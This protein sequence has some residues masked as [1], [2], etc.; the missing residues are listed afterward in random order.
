LAAIEGAGAADRG[1]SGGPRRHEL[2]AAGQVGVFEKDPV[3]YVLQEPAGARDGTP[4]PLAIVYSYQAKFG[5]TPDAILAQW[6]DFAGYVAVVQVDPTNQ[7]DCSVAIAEAAIAGYNVDRNAILVT[8]WQSGHEVG[9]AVARRPDLFRF[10]FSD[11]TWGGTPW[12]GV[13][14]VSEEDRARLRQVHVYMKLTGADYKTDDAGFDEAR[15]AGVRAFWEAL[16]VQDL[17]IENYPARGTEPYGTS[18]CIGQ[19]ASLR[20]REWFERKLREEAAR[21]DGGT[22]GGR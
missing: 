5:R 2:V 6:G 10:G 15:T 3:R 12:P 4:L 18:R 20:A 7:T 11:S 8:D 9:N 19:D 16:G 13:P 17:L 1:A 22:E 21:P 14:S